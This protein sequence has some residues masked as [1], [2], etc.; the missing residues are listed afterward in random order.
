VRP[1]PAVP[2]QPR[3]GVGLLVLLWTAW[4]VLPAGFALSALGK[5][6]VFFGES[7]TEAEQAD[8]RQ[9]FVVAA[10]AAVAV[11]LAGVLLSLRARRPGSAQAF[12]L[13]VVV[14]TVVALVVVVGTAPP[15][16]RSA[17]PPHRPGGACQEHSGGDNRCPGD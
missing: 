12:G 8:A 4:V 9:L 16:P 2:T 10:V 11:P 1:D 3:G 7:P 17:I 6:L 13:A 5:L 14:G 15:E